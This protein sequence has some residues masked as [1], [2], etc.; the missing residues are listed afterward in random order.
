[1]NI[2]ESH[3]APS[4]NIKDDGNELIQSG[5]CVIE[6]VPGI[7]YRWLRNVTTH[8]IDNNLAYIEGSVNEAVNYAVYNFRTQLEIMV[9]K[10]GFSG[11]VNAT[12]SISVGVLGQLVTQG[13]ITKY[14]NLTI[15]LA[16]D[17]MTI[18]VE[19]APVIPVNFIKS[20]IHLVS[21]SFSA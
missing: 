1:L 7:G 3:D 17:V 10:K 2:V 21:N 14:Q 9:G 16:N 18:D 11:T 8:L 19:I 5:L 15:E 6:K 12:A 4:Y 20:T 13:A